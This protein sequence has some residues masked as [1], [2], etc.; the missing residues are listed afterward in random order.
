[1]RER[2]SKA[3]CAPRFLAQARRSGATEIISV[4]GVEATFAFLAE[5]PPLAG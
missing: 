2:D 4:D 1:M 5:E 3:L